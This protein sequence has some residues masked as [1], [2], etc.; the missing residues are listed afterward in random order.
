MPLFRLFLIA[1]L[2]VVAPHAA[3]A[4]DVDTTSA[5]QKDGTAKFGDPDDKVPYPHVADDGAM[6]QASGPQNGPSLSFSVNG[7]QDDPF[8]LRTQPSQLRR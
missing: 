6:E 1:A 4:F 2:A 5:T 7:L 3:M 8:A